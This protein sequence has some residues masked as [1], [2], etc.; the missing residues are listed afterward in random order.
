MH[1]SC[2]LLPVRR[3]PMPQRLV[4]APTSLDVW[5]CMSQMRAW[6]HHVDVSQMRQVSTLHGK[7]NVLIKRARQLDHMSASI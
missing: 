7:V 4:D 1:S 5:T 3:R 6:S 2:F